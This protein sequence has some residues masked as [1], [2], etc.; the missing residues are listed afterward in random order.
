MIK[1]VIENCDEKRHTAFCHCEDGSDDFQDVH[2][3]E[4]ENFCQ[5]VE[6]VPYIRVLFLI[7]LGILI[8]FHI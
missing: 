2:V 6:M 4:Q 5:I 1:V 3:A 7:L 8:T